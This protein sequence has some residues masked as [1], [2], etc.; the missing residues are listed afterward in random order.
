MTQTR[1]RMRPWTS[2]GYFEAKIDVA[3][4][5]RFNKM[6]WGATLGPR[7]LEKMGQKWTKP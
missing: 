6:P 5:R 2:F 7:F 4:L 3:S 1:S